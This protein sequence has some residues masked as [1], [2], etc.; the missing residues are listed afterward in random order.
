[1]LARALLACYDPTLPKVG[2][3]RALARQAREE[4]IRRQVLQL[5]GTALS[6]QSTVPAMITASLGIAT[7]G[8][9]FGDDVERAA[10]LDILVRTET[11]HGWP[12]GS[13][14]ASLRQAWR[15]EY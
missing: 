14:Q 6:N 7:C 15:W 5:C 3:R 9:R 2:P 4:A 11:D 13:L 12:T 8:D 1:M 10:L